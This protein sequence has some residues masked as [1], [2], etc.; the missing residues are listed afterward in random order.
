MKMDLPHRRYNPL[1]DEWVLVSPHRTQRPWQGQTEISREDPAPTHDPDCHLCPGNV[2]T[3]SALNPDYTGTYVFDND[4]PALLPESEESGTNEVTGGLFRS[5]SVEGTCRVICYA[6]EH[7][8]TMAQMNLEQITSVIESWS[9]QYQELVSSYTW[10]QI[11]ENKGELMGCS[12]PHPHGQIWASAHL[13]SEPA[14]SDQSQLTYYREQGTRLLLDYAVEEK[15]AGDRVVD[16]NDDWISVVPWWATWP[17]QVL[18]LPLEPISHLGELAQHQVASLAAILKQLLVRYDNL[19]ECSFPYSMGWHQSP[20]GRD[21]SHW[22]MHAHFYPPLL[23]SASVKKHMVGYEMLA[24]A[25]RDL[26][27]EQA[28]HALRMVSPDVRYDT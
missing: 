10:V 17:F 23:R 22:Q 7:H 25:Q 6:P 11:F 8:L 4:F 9:L 13:P 27:P 19:F 1:L 21:S 5:K 12:S 24:E 28:A 16:L 3:N 26:T 20:G 15:I 18:L 14:R 2:R